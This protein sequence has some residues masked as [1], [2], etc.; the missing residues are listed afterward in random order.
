MEKKNFKSELYVAPM[1][2]FLG[3]EAEGVLCSSIEVYDEETIVW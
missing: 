3:C 1:I 2:E